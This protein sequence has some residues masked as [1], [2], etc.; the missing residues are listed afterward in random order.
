MLKWHG[1]TGGKKL[2]GRNNFARL[3]L[4]KKIAP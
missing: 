4:S 2:G 1:R 3:H